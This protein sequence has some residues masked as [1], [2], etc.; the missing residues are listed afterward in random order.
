M[1][2][3]ENDAP[4]FLDASIVVRYLVQDR[5]MVAEQVRHIVEDYPDLRLTEG[6]IA[7]S[8]YVLMRVYQV[9]RAAVV[10]ALIALVRRANVRVHGIDKDIAIQA[11]LLCR[12]S[13]RVSFGDAMLW[14][15]AR[16]SDE[17]AIVFTLDARFPA[18][19]IKV[20]QTF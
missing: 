8:A 16:S 14:A 3:R 9:P 20:R 11:L 15:V 7:E 5:P 12:A 6:T 19:G 4:G 10:D 18:A 1:S 13:G 2:V 17:D